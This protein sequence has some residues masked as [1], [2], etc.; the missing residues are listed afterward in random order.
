MTINKLCFEIHDDNFKQCNN[1]LKR[2]IV[3]KVSEAPNPQ[4]KKNR[5]NSKKSYMMANAHSFCD[6]GEPFLFSFWNV[7]SYCIVRELD[8]IL[9]IQVSHFWQ[10]IQAKN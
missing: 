8:Y 10:K 1:N 3:T 2:K 5:E 4:D 6:L 9:F 7:I